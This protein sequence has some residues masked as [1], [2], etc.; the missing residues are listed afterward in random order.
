MH[1]LPIISPSSWRPNPM[2]THLL[3]LGPAGGDF[4]APRHLGDEGTD[5]DDKDSAS[6]YSNYGDDSEG[7][8]TIP[9]ALGSLVSRNL[10]R[11]RASDWYGSICEFLTTGKCDSGHHRAHPKQPP[12]LGLR[13]GRWSVFAHKHDGPTGDRHTSPSL[14]CLVTLAICPL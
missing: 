10:S 12:P 13:L 2:K 8:L 5:G 3:A 9:T 6:G 7:G 11:Y 1:T 4:D 14:C